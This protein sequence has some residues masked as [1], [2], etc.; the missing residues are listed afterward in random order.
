MSFTIVHNL[1]LHTNSYFT[2]DLIFDTMLAI[3]KIHM[4]TYHEVQNDITLPDYNENME[5]FRTLYGKEF[6]E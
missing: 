2:N 3:M 1:K 5:R 4:P 6:L